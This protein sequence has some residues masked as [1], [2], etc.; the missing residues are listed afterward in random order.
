M[1]RYSKQTRVLVAVDCIIFGFDGEHLK[2]LLIQ[3]GFEP[4]KNKWSLMGGFI[5]P[6]EG[7]EAAASRI[8]KQLTGLEGVYM[9]QMHVFGEPKRDPIERTLSITYFAFIDV[10]KYEKQLSEEYH[11]EWF[12]LKDV[13]KLIFDHNEMVEMAREKLRYKAAL[14]PILFELLPEK[15]TI[16]QIQTLYE[17]VY[18][19][20]LDKRNFSRKLLSTGLLIRQD[21]KDKENSKKGAYFYKLDP[22]IYKDKFQSFLNFIPNPQALSA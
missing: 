14:H 16:P 6:H 13:P 2:L 12:H 15:F 5:E 22:G 7:P 4:E 8:L 1:T 9:E 18:D 21:E 10:H 3:R 19:T 20:V 11:A 17:N